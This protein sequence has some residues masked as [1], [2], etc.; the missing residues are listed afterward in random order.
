MLCRKFT[1]YE[2]FKCIFARFVHLNEIPFKTVVISFLSY[3]EIKIDTTPFV[4]IK[5]TINIKTSTTTKLSNHNDDDEALSNIVYNDYDSS[6]DQAA[7]SDDN[8]HKFNDSN[9]NLID[10]K[11][12]RR[13]FLTN[14]KDYLKMQSQISSDSQLCLLSN[15]LILFLLIGA[16][17]LTR[18]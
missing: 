14:S 15:I 4:E 7:T 1:W 12:K 17:I 13:H 16:F 11:D 6:N 2:M 3:L 10:W 18:K 5:P 9:N 8:Q